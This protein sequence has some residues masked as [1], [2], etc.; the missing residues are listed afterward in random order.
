MLFCAGMS[1]RLSK[2][3]LNAYVVIEIVPSWQRSEKT[4]K[5]RNKLHWCAISMETSPFFFCGIVLLFCIT[6]IKSF[7]RW[8]KTCHSAGRRPTTQRFF[9]S[10]KK[11]HCQSQHTGFFLSL[12]PKWVLKHTHTHTHTQNPLFGTST[13]KQVGTAPAWN[14]RKQAAPPIFVP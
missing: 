8:L 14:Q 6:F 5:D 10:K 11:P 4:N 13:S 3:F 12:W 7:S 1:P 2:L 9:I